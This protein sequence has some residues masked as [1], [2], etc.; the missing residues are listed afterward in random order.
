MLT[1]PELSGV[2]KAIIDSLE[3]LLPFLRE[4]IDYVNIEKSISWARRSQEVINQKYRTRKGTITGITTLSPVTPLS[5][6]FLTGGILRAGLGFEGE[7]LAGMDAAL[8][9]L[10]EV[11]TDGL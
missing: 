6:V 7:I 2:A 11:K 9:A 3:G 5:N 8:L 10:G 1:D 4:N